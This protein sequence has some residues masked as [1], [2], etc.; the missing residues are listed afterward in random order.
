MHFRNS[1]EDRYSWN[2]LRCLEREAVAIFSDASQARPVGF[3]SGE[4]VGAIGIL[5]CEQPVLF[6]P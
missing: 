5:R 2:C 3:T 4:A 6:A 1:D